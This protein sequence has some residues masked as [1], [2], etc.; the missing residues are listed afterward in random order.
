MANIFISY[1]KS[2]EPDARLLSAFLEAN[3][4]SVWWD[5]DL[6]GGDKY[7]GA[8]AA[9][10]SKARAVVVI[11]TKTS[12]D[13]N[14]VQSEAGRALREQKLI[15]VRSGGMEYKDIPPPFD[16]VHTVTLNNREQILAAVAGQL[17][18]PA[19]PAPLWK[20]LKFDLLAW[21]GVLGGAITL[22]AHIDG[23]LKLASLFQWLLF[24]WSALLKHMWQA[25]LF[26]RFDVSAYDAEVLTIG[27]LMT[28]AVLYS[29]L[30][31]RATKCPPG[32]EVVAPP[33]GLGG[34]SKR[35]MTLATVS[36]IWSLFP[37][38]III[39]LGVANIETRQEA[40]FWHDFDSYVETIFA[41]DSDCARFMKNFLR[42][43]DKPMLVGLMIGD[44]PPT[45]KVDGCFK[46][47]GA[48][49]KRHDLYFLA[50]FHGDEEK[51]KS[52]VITA[53]RSIN[54]TAIGVTLVLALV[55]SPIYMPFLL[56]WVASLILPLNIQVSVL[57]QRLW[58]TLILFGGIIIVN[59]VAIGIESG[60]NW[61]KAVPDSSY[62]ID[63]NRPDDRLGDTQPLEDRHAVVGA[64]ERSRQRDDRHSRLQRR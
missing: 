8:I 16:N 46:S 40:R 11:W 38:F 3:G 17:A 47:S 60:V 7:R 28:S 18:K 5:R 42:N 27:L 59:F 21:L 50:V 55:L 51:N 62:D 14:W 24:N 23:I 22:L 64:R 10:L 52:V 43:A 15:P 34:R 61:L 63:I 31:N 44:K 29:S 53:V 9:E 32:L 26:F 30:P 37:I 57:S 45:Q 58:R 6:V 54:N 41:S 2:D 48:E 49:E 39:V 35:R 13:S 4:Y 25:L 19:L 20:Q 56:Y 33:A 1:S 36:L 12:V